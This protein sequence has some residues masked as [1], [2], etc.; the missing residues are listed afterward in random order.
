M[1]YETTDTVGV[2]GAHPVFEVISRTP[3]TVI[4]FAEDGSWT[5]NIPKKFLDFAQMYLPRIS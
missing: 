4:D 2:Y 3:A 5:V 1:I